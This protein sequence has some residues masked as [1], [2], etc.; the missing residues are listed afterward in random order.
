MIITLEPSMVVTGAAIMVAEENIVVRDGEP[1][2]L[3][4]RAGR[5]L[6]VI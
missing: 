3:S 6:P 1:E 5:E 4:V 2:L